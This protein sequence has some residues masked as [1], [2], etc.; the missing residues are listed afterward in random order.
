MQSFK[1]SFIA[2]LT[3]LALLA[4]CGGGGGGSAALPKTTAPT[5]SNPTGSLSPNSGTFAWGQQ[6]V[7]QLPYTGPVKAGNLSMAVSVRMQNGQGLVQYAQQVSDPSSA[8]YRHWLTP[9]QIA[10]RFGATQTD[11]QT[12]AQYLKQYGLKVG[13]WPQREALS[14]SGTVA[15]FQQAFGTTFGTYTYK[16]K[17]VVAPASAPHMPS[18]VPI[19]GAIGM[20]NASLMRPYFIHGNNALFFGYSPQQVAT[21]FD[22]SGAYSKS[23]DGSGISV[24]IIG[25]GP[26]LDSHGAADTVAYGAYWKAKMATVTQVNS[27]PQAATLA[28]GQTGTGAVDPN[29][30]GLASPPPV[31][32]P[33]QQTGPVPDYTTCNPED[34]E[35]QLD[36]ESVASLA[37][38]SSVLF[39]MA[40]NPGECVN[41]NTGGFD[42]PVSGACPSGDITYP[43]EGIQIADDEI[44]QAIADDK[45]D[46]ISMSFGGPENLNEAFGY[47]APSG[48]QPG[49]GQVEMASLAAEGIAV[50]V[51]SGDDGAWECFDPATGNPLG[52]P[53]ASYPAS[54]PNVVA[55]GAVNIPLDESGNLIGEIQAWA[56]D[57][58]LGGNGQFGNNVGSGGGVS[59]V[60]AAPA[61]QSTTLGT[62]MRTL[63]DMSLD[64]DPNTGQSILVYGSF[65][66]YTS[67]FAEGGT[68]M[69]APEAAAQWALVLEACKNSST[70]NKGGTTGYR[71]GNPAPLFYSIYGTSSYAK[72][73]YSPANFTPQLTYNKVFA[74]I[75]YGG[76]QA[77]PATPGPGQST[78]PPTSGYESGPGY[79]QV[80]GIGAPST[81]H[82]IQAITG[83][84]IP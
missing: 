36:T 62:S 51:S 11:Y 66:A 84:Q 81:G 52:T 13:M 60:F 77:V 79:D 68:S 26:I 24:G 5:G 38:G 12:A 45:A 59:S 19:V 50:F 41:P 25:T 31:T 74:D 80:T 43:L 15:Q 39:Y 49:V 64:G 9:D 44:Q 16:G 71:L 82:L 7:S 32:A 63:P 53:C 47:I 69:S 65:P 30:A 28:N 34:I 75:I 78:P 33:C 27:L 22:F 17:P 42:L 10:A 3:G 46:A 73:T 1:R 58:T 2:G 4:G 37:P 72:A 18:G 20:M 70:C 57:T 40:Y 21:G 83:T 6:I 56:D 23:I 14:V 61:W 76:N 55:V 48:A 54:D 35:A 29:P 67:T 8:L